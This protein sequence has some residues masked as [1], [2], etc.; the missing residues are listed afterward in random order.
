MTINNTGGPVRIYLDGKAEFKNGSSINILGSPTNFSI[1][2]KSSQDIILKN[3]TTFKGL[4]YAPLADIH[5]YNTAD[6]YGVVW[7]DSVYL[8]N[9][10]NFWVD[11]S[12]A[13]PLRPP[14]GPWDWP[15]TPLLL[16]GWEELP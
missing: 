1:I 3:N 16:V 11:S 8:N 15:N 7:G 6:F 14:G 12:V 5:V 9:S 2:S 4:I 13:G 10:G